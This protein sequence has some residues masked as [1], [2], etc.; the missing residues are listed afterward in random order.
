MSKET[1]V[2]A[3]TEDTL[4]RRRWQ[5]HRVGAQP[6]SGTGSHARAAHGR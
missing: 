5:L 6:P 3:L 1:F 2:N 4:R